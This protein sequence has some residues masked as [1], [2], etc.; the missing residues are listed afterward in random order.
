MRRILGIV[1]ALALILAFTP[2]VS[3]AENR[4]VSVLVEG[5][6]VVFADQNPLIIE[7]RT[8]VPVRGVFENLNFIVNWN[9]VTRQA[10]LTRGNDVV[11]ITIGSDVFTTNGVRHTLDVPAQS[12]GGR[13]MLPLR[14][15]LESVGYFLE[16]DAGTSTVLISSHP[17]PTMPHNGAHPPIGHTLVGTWMWMESLFYIFNADGSG[18]M[19]TSPILWSA[20]NGVLSICTTPNLCGGTCRSPSLWDYTLAGNRLTLVSLQMPDLYFVYTRG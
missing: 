7:G 12:I 14:L 1:L 19:V 17:H 15:V 4:A 3:A 2:G 10:I 18:T 6:R 11:V 20:S 9:A 13:T 16:W 8:L 5:Q